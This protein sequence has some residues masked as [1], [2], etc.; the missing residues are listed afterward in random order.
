MN[1][2]TQ[3]EQELLNSVE[4]G[5]WQSKPNLAQR[6]RTLQQYARQ[7]LNDKKHFDVTLSSN[8]FDKLNSF[9][10]KQGMSYQVFA[11]N[12]LH[13]YIEEKLQYS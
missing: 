6:K 3:E 13:Q 12:I 11:E 10:L 8:D 5:E 7:H 4:N 9:A 2:L 1:N